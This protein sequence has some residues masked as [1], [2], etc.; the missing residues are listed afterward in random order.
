[1]KI[2]TLITFIVSITVVL[3]LAGCGEN[4]V[5]GTPTTSTLADSQTCIGCHGTA[6]SPVTGAVI[7]EEWKLSRHN[8][9]TS[10]KKFPGFGAGCRDC[11]E[12]QAGHPNNCGRCH[13]G[14][15]SANNVTG[16]DV[17]DNP[18]RDL[19]CFKCHHTNT[20]GAPHFNNLTSSGYPASFVSSQNL[21]KCRNCHNP[22]DPTTRMAVNTQ[23]A[24]SGHGDTTAGPWRSYDF[25][26]RGN[27]IPAPLTYGAICVRCHT[28]TG[29]INF[30]TSNFTDVHAWGVSTD[31]TKE[32]LGCNACHDDGAGN[33]YSF[34]VRKVLGNGVGISAYYNYSGPRSAVS[35]KINNVA[36]R[37][38]DAASSNLCVLCHVGRANGAVIKRADLAGLDFGNVSR[39]SSHDFPAGANLY[40]RGGFEFYTS[41]A[42]YAHYFKHDRIGMNNESSTGYMG[43]CIAC[44]MSSPAKHSFMPLSSA[45]TTIQAITATACANCHKPTTYGDFTLTPALLQE[46]KDGL[47]AALA[48]IRALEI[49]RNLYV[50]NPTTQRWGYTTNWNAPFG[51]GVVP[52]SGGG[53]NN[54]DALHAGAYTMG[55]SFNY[56]LISADPGAYA[57][58]SIYIRML[59]YD[60]IDWLY[61][62]A[63]DLDTEAAISWLFA[64]GKIN[65]TTRDTALAYLQ[66]TAA[67]PSGAGGTRP[68]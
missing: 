45:G 1:M 15:P 34:K 41:A 9:E 66:G 18:D 25:K 40:Q 55:V 35:V 7:A 16:L 6:V 31:K 59:I 3:T 26:T 68:H 4:T 51:A 38:P 42:R 33:A 56:A 62:G 47:T 27:T 11:H 28:T 48:V 58:N 54:T 22:H 5:V 21:G 53:I 64:N 57:H 44:H 46:Q 12:P 29:F 52:G 39:I 10:G 17:S 8:T 49:Q 32:V 60:S 23:W 43:P 20:L 19:K 14:P 36:T 24:A 30:V 13:G 2:R 61:N 63:M 37:Y 67:T 65:S 50:L